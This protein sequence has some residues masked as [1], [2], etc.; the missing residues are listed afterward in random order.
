MQ[1]QIQLLFPDRDRGVSRLRNET[2]ANAINEESECFTEGASRIQ[3]AREAS[4][5]VSS[6]AS[7]PGTQRPTVHVYLNMC[8]TE[9]CIK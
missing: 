2:G 9:L 4:Q 6:I 8:Y 1:V 5:N 3:L 7:A